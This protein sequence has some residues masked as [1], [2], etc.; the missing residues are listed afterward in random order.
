[1]NTYIIIGAP[2][3][4]KSPWIRR[5]IQD[6]RCL[7]FDIQN[8]YGQ[9][10]KYAGQQPVGL[11]DNCRSSGAFRSRYTGGD[12]MEFISIAS[13]KRDTIVVFEEATAFFEGK[14]HKDVRRFLINRFHSGNVSLFV[15]HSINSVPPR[16]METCNYVVLFKTLDEYDTVYRKYSRLAQ[17]FDHLQD[18]PDGEFLI[19]KM[20]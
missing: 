8:E 15:F 18:A 14:T 5:F 3:Q 16:F 20:I 17:A 12:V 2:G 19:F 1:M 7:V 6:K 9:R 11:S 10:T 13:K 4:G